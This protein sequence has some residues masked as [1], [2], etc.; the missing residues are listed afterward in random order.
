MSSPLISIII[1]CYNSAK[2]IGRAIESMLCQTYKNIE[3]IIAD[4]NSTDNLAEVIAPFLE[5]YKNIRYEK[6]P[7]NDPDRQTPTGV[8]INVGFSA[9]N[10]GLKFAKGDLITFQDADDGSCS[11]RLEVQYE[12]MKRYG[13]W[14][15]N[16]DWQKYQDKYNCKYLN[17]QIK[18]EDVIPTKEIL[19]LAKKTRPKLFKY[20]F[21]KNEYSNIL[22]KALRKIIRKYFIDW[23]PYPGCAGMPLFKKEMLEKC[24]FRQLYQRTRPS[25][26]GKG[27]DRD[28]NFS[29]AKTFKNSIVI[30]APLHLWRVENDNPSYKE[31]KYRPK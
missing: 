14:H 18:D 30:K 6:V 10:H 12:A 25:I 3:I 9:R 23:T 7:F 15:V 31:E 8:N 20:P 17:Y 19:A 26:T 4:D 27:A 5:K 28:F 21:S 29:L 1:P 13:A 22:S 11:N 2:Y 16:I 24:K